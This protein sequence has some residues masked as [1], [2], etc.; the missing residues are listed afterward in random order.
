M[1]DLTVPADAIEAVVRVLDANDAAAGIGPAEGLLLRVLKLAEEVGE[2]SAALIGRA[3]QNPRKGVTHT[4]S[5]VRAELC[6][7]ALTALVALASTTDGWAAEF[8]SA[9]ESKTGRLRVRAEVG[10]DA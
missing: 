4:A 6:D 10:V 9:V 8:E 2:V 5:D 7:V 1:P 3:G